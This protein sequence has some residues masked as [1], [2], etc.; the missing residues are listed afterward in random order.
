MGPLE[1]GTVGLVMTSCT[2]EV[3]VVGSFSRQKST[4]RTA[5]FILFFSTPI[6]ASLNTGN[7]LEDS[8]R[9]TARGTRLENQAVGGVG[10]KR[11]MPVYN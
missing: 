3:S 11:F 5:Y 4:G 10:N 7:D 8:R 2:I 1:H 9:S 6:L